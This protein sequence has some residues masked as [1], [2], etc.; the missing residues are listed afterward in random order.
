M[1][2]SA[3][4][5]I[6]GAARAYHD[7]TIRPVSRQFITIPMHSHAYGKKPAE[8]AG[9]FVW[10]SKNGNAFLAKNEGR[11]L[12]LMWLLAREAF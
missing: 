3:A 2:G 5:A 6:P 7:I 1:S 4:V 8:E 10:T 9:M 11:E 12:R